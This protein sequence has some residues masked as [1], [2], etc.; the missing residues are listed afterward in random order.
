LFIDEARPEG[1]PW[2]AEF[3]EFVKAEGGRCIG[4]LILYGARQAD[5]ED[6]VQEGL[7]ALY[8]TWPG[9]VQR[10]G[11]VMKAAFRAYH[12]VQLRETDELRRALRG[13]YGKRL[14][15]VE[16]NL[17]LAWIEERSQVLEILQHLPERQRLIMSYILIGFTPAE[18]A[19]ELRV[20]PSTVRVH[21]SRAR[22]TLRRRLSHAIAA[23][24]AEV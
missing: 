2:D 3:T 6:A 9:I 21:L 16:I 4:Q 5:A 7:A 10:R 14:T 1:R 24:G 17:D 19:D 23:S 15:T 22:A 12:K 11:F 18:T 13:G 20:Q 8:R